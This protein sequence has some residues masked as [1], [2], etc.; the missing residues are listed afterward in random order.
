MLLEHNKILYVKK[1]MIH[2]RDQ[3]GVVLMTIDRIYY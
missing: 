1:I 3:L 2:S